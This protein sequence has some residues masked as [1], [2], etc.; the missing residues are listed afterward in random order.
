MKT[1]YFVWH[2]ESEHSV[3]EVQLGA[4]SA[5]TEKG[6]RQADFIAKRCRSFSLEAIIASPYK[7]ARDTAEIINRQLGLKVESSEL[8]EE[9]RRPS[10][11][12]GL[13][14]NDEKWKDAERMT[15]ENICQPGWR[16]SDEENMDDLLERSR[17]ALD[18]LANRTEGCI[19][20]VTHGWFLRALVTQVVMGSQVTPEIT[21]RFVRNFYSE[22]TSL[23]VIGYDPNRRGP[24]DP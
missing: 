4:D 2:G 13:N 20:V 22:N 17:R 14:R 5:L 6:I 7:R 18:L 8:F 23:S 19:L 3:S 9:R 10:E 16:Y 12:I 11:Q 1:I 15:R 24:E 21:K